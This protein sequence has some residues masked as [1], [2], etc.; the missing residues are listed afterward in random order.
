M[1]YI[2]INRLYFYIFNKIK[3]KENK[4][5]ARFYKKKKDTEVD[6]IICLSA[7]ACRNRGVGGGGLSVYK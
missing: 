7:E 3:H 6:Y 1:H 5:Q 4:Q 2:Y